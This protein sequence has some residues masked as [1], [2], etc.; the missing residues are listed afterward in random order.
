MIRNRNARKVVRA[1]KK[2]ALILWKTAQELHRNGGMTE[3]QLVEIEDEL[4][5]L[6]PR[7]VIVAS[8]GSGSLAH[9]PYRV[10]QKRGAS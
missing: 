6:P 2:R 9:R 8:A 3:A 10:H 5:E 7:A 1:A 4:N